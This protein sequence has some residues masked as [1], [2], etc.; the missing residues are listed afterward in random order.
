MFNYI[1][2]AFLI[3]SAESGY[4]PNI[5]S[6]GVC[7]GNPW[8]IKMDNT[9]KVEDKDFADKIQFEIKLQMIK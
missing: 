9:K 5:D 4:Y 7:G 1:K 3:L 2:E 6:G 8:K